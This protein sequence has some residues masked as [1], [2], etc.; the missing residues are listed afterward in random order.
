M[1]NH[2]NIHPFDRLYKII[3]I[4]RSPEGCPWDREQSPR[5]LRES[6]IEETYECIEA[7]DT[8]SIH[9]LREELGDLYLLITMISYMNEQLGNFSVDAVLDEI[10]EKLI[11]RHPHV[12]AEKKAISI[13]KIME[14]W[15]YIKE[16]VEGK[17][18][19]PSIL[20]NVKKSLPPLE[21]AVKLQKKAAKAGFD[22]PNIDP[23]FEKLEEETKELKEAA[24]NNDEKAIEEEIGDM[25]FT[26]VNISRHFNTDPSI[27]L[28]HTNQKFISRFQKIEEKL[29]KKGLPLQDATLEELDALWEEAK[30]E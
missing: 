6:L 16:H 8:G 12:F 18:K 25:L 22:W 7:I 20:S 21:K 13:P 15:E 26:L 30:K 29:Q 17:K 9:N 3:Q 24:R 14:N 27:A 23:V 10:G 4:L 19:N 11:R 5:T 28:N 1:N 2:E